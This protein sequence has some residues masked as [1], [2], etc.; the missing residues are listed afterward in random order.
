MKTNQVNDSKVNL[1]NM[2][3]ISEKYK[4]LFGDVNA[5]FGSKQN[6]SNFN[7]LK[8]SFDP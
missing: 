2:S 3:N 6:D 4:S 5:S 1:A 7:N 8:Y